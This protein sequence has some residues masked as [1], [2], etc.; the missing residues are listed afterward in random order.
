MYV[1]PSVQPKFVVLLTLY[2]EY[3]N[4]FSFD[5]LSRVLYDVYASVVD[6][7]ICRLFCYVLLTYPAFL[8]YKFELQGIMQNC[9]LQC[10]VCFAHCLYLIKS[11][12]NVLIPSSYHWKNDAIGIRDAIKLAYL[13]SLYNKQIHTVY[14]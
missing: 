6:Y 5:P 7:V 2:C 1:L 11:L 4:C 14:L 12:F 8:S 13:I 9:L 10:M 3:P